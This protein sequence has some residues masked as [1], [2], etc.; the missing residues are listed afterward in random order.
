MGRKILIV[1]DE[2]KIARFIEMELNYEGYATEKAADGQTGLELARTGAFDLILLDLMLPGMSG[3]EVLRRIRRS[4][5]VPVIVLTARDST[6]DK[7]S[8]LDGG[9]DDYMTKP[10]ATEELLARIRN[11]LRKSAPAESE[12][13]SAFGVVLD[14]ARRT[15]S[16]NGHPVSLT[17]REFDLLCYLMKNKGMVLSRE[18]LLEN[19]WGYEFEGET[20]AVDVFV[21]FLRSKIDDV[22]GIKLIT[23]VRGVGYV[24]KDEE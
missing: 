18:V 17:K 4:S 12:Q 24:I 13:L 2:Q 1:E 8:G 14:P 7:V 16:V 11:A 23:T 6:M 3:M 20:N 21:R 10:F 5:D 22:Y 15:V 19:V 9:A